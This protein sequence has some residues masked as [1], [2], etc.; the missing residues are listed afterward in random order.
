MNFI[1]KQYMTSRDSSSTVDVDFRSDTIPSPFIIISFSYL[2]ITLISCP[3][4]DVR[5]KRKMAQF[6]CLL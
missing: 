4:K 6:S 2:C 3:S 5:M 1:C